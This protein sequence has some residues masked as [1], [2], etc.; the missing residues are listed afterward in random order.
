MIPTH[1][2]EHVPCKQLVGLSIS[3]FGAN[4][5][6]WHVA[7]NPA[8]SGVD[9][10]RML[11]VPVKSGTQGRTNQI[12]ELR[13]R[14]SRPPGFGR[15]LEMRWSTEPTGRQLPIRGGR[16]AARPCCRPV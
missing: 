10:A 6:A 1:L 2:M 7:L 9:P 16:K 4:V 12:G 8:H 14:E 3:R 5:L 15:A 11:R 13:C